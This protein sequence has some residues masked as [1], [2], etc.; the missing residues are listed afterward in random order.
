MHVFSREMITTRQKGGLVV[1]A[2][3]K[4]I[5]LFSK[6]ILVGIPRQETLEVPIPDSSWVLRM[7]RLARDGTVAP[8]SPDQ[9]LRRE[10][11]KGNIRI[12]LLFTDTKIFFVVNVDSALR[13]ITKLKNMRANEEITP[14]VLQVI[15][16]NVRHTGLRLG[17]IC[18]II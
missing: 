1:Y 17:V 2:E 12:Q 4:W 8:V 10:Q 16:A 15:C 3:R 14:V 5:G 7:C 6:D 9:I 18:S 13:E 11:G